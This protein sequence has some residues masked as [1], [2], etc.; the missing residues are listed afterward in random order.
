[1]RAENRTE[2][3]PVDEDAELLAGISGG[4][5][6]AFESLYDRYAGAAF[7]VAK[8]VC[9]DPSLAEDVVQEA[10]LS[11]WRRPASYRP[12][13]GRVASYLF[14]VVHNKAVDTVR[15]EESLRR[16]EQAAGVV[17]DEGGVDDVVESALLALRRDQ[18]RRALGPLSPLQRQ[19]IELAYFDGLTGSEVA[20]KL[21]IPLGTAKTR[22]RDGM[23]HLRRVLGSEGSVIA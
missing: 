14:G 12:E 23:I 8:R 7:G 21:G 18:V 9:G 1:L 2:D 10:F 17:E 3:P 6:A 11:I 15:H 4:S 22:L 16:R 20:A 19:A 5:R 13:R